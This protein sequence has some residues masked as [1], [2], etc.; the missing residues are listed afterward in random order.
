MIP[1]GGA[2][3]A[4]TFPAPSISP[5]RVEQMTNTWNSQDIDSE[6]PSVLQR[7][8]RSPHWILHGLNRK[9][10]TV[11]Y[12]Y[13]LFI[14]ISHYTKTP[15]SHMQ[16][17]WHLDMLHVFSLAWPD[18]VVASRPPPH[19]TRNSR[20]PPW[21]SRC[22]AEKTCVSKAGS[23]ASKGCQRSILRLPNL[24]IGRLMAFRLYLL[25]C[26]QV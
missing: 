16:H 19:W 13:I 25:R 26:S 12:I 5:A 22:E 14:Y 8:L 15:H 20:D 21:R 4:T 24:A 3:W 7:H 9:E 6:G 11:L 18:M 1:S 17:F 23:L 10:Q 2:P